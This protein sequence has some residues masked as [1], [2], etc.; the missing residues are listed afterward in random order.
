MLNAL[1]LKPELAEVDELSREYHK[2][3]LFRERRLFSIRENGTLKAIVMVNLS[4]LGLNLS[5]LT[6]CINVFILDTEDFAVAHLRP[7]IAR[8][9]GLIGREDMPVLI[10]PLFYA[11]QQGVDYEKVYNLWVCSLQYSDPYFRYL[12]RLLRFV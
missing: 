10:Y 8:V 5:D 2:L 12:K 9:L 11:E 7:I 1:D 6:N 3:G 4:D